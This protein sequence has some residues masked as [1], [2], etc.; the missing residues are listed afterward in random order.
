MQAYD[1]CL[2]WYWIYDHDF[3]RFMEE[4][5]AVH[6]VTLL[7]IT[8]ANLLQAVN[9]LYA[10]GIGFRTLL[11]RAADDLRFE[12]I[13][14]FALEH[15]SHRLNA[16][17]YSHWSE[18]K[19]TMHLELIEAGVQTPYT[20][21]L[22]PF[23][24]HPLLPALDLAPF[25][26]RFVVKPAVGGGGEGVKMNASTLEDVQRARLEFPDQKYLVQEQVD[27]RVLRGR[28]A[29]FRIFYTGGSCIPCWW[30]PVTHVYAILTP[31]EE[32]EF[33]LGPLHT[34]TSTIAR[35]CKLDWFS[36]EIA[37]TSDG[38]FVA[39]DYVNDGIDTR[40]QSR[41]ADGVPDQVMRLMT[42]RLASLVISEARV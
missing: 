22:A 16:P 40:I 32:I 42:D 1:L 31:D 37:V 29:W 41:A 35:V 34:I 10:G 17:E 19:A 8:P 38:R 9:D 36:T 30:H 6:Q 2:P 13:R 20:T 25:G 39:V 7:Q 33:S 27:A 21:I 5:C 28:D 12:P 11:D 14:R 24:A 4:A 15:G 3:V 18:D 26:A 23:V